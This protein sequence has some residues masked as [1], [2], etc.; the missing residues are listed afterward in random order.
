MRSPGRDVGRSSAPAGRPPRRSG[1]GATGFHGSVIENCLPT[2]VATSTAG[3]SPRGAWPRSSSSALPVHVRGIEEVHPGRRRGCTAHSD[4]GRRW[5]IGVAEPVAPD[6][7]RAKPWGLNREAGG[8]RCTRRLTAAGRERLGC[9]RLGKLVPEAPVSAGPSRVFKRP[10]ACPRTPEALGPAAVRRRVLG[11][12]RSRVSPHRLR[13]LA[14]GGA[15][16]AIPRVPPTTPSRA[17]RAPRL[18]PGGQLLRYRG[19]VRGTG[20]RRA[21]GQ[22]LAGIRQRVLV[23]TKVGGN[24]YNRAVNPLLL[25]RIA[26]RSAGRSPS[27]RPTSRSR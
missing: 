19:R 6:G 20:T 16:S 18:R 4:S 1:P 11:P 17:R 23:A 25:G 10:T 15:G 2:L 14:I 21:P 26:E 22:A 13:A 3:G 12:H 5:T 27:S 24:F 9:V 7:P 8:G